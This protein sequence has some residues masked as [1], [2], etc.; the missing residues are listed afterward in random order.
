[1]KILLGLTAAALELP[2]VLKTMAILL[3]TVACAITSIQMCFCLPCL[4]MVKSCLQAA[5]FR[6]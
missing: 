6:V 1:M 5:S 2:N 4:Q 3:L